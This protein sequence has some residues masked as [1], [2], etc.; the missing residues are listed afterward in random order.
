[1]RFA[2]RRL[3]EG[4]NDHLSR[5]LQYVVVATCIT[6][7]RS[8]IMHDCWKPLLVCQSIAMAND[9]DSLEIAS[10]KVGKVGDGLREGD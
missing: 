9:D 7:G 6:Q 5:L 2:N 4:L 8:F 3:A 1:M 10:T